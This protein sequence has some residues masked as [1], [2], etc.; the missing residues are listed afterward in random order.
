[1]T[2]KIL[3][4]RMDMGEGTSKEVSN[5]EQNTLTLSPVEG[6]AF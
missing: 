4:L 5:R 1:M 2:V 3:R 6:R